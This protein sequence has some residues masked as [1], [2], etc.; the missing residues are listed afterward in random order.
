MRSAEEI[1]RVK[2]LRDLPAIQNEN[3]ARAR[4]TLFRHALRLDFSEDFIMN[5]VPYQDILLEISPADLESLTNTTACLDFMVQEA[6]LFGFTAE[7]LQDSP[8]I[9]IF[10]PIS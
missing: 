3:H 9:R 6:Q 10:N 5:N 2:L 1:R 7:K 4:G 8:G